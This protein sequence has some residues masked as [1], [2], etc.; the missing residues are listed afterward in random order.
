MTAGILPARRVRRAPPLPNSVR[1]S[2]LRRTSDTAELLETHRYGGSRGASDAVTGR[3]DFGPRASTSDTASITEARDCERPSPGQPRHLTRSLR[4]P[5]DRTQRATTPGAVN[6]R[7][8]A[9]VSVLDC[10]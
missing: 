8:P 2:A 9:T 7:R 6:R 3:A 10:R 5:D 1:V 4:Q